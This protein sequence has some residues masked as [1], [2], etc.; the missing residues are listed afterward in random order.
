MSRVT[1]LPSIPLWVTFQQRPSASNSTLQ[2]LIP[3]LCRYAAQIG[4]SVALCSRYDFNY[5]SLLSELSIGGEW[6]QR[7]RTKPK[8]KSRMLED[9]SGMTSSFWKSVSSSEEEVVSMIK[10]RV[11]TSSVSF[12]SQLC[13]SS[14]YLNESCY[15]RLV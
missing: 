5:H 14:F 3:V 10:A 1:A 2:L 9:R 6:F 11:S 8:A 13:L 4:P 7:R 12:W 15:R